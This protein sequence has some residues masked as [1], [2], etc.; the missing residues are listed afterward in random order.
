MPEQTVVPLAQL[1]TLG[2]GGPARRLVSGDSPV[3]M[4]RTV[5]ACDSV[6]ERLLVLAGGSNVVIPDRGFDGTVLLVRTR[7]VSLLR[8][9][10][11]AV[12]V[13]AQAGE[14]WDAL[15]ARCVA[16]GLAGL[17]CLAGIPGSVGATPIQNVGAYGQ[18]VSQTIAAVQAYDRRHHQVIELSPMDC[19]FSY[20][21]S[22]LKDLDR[23]VV[24]A[25]T[26][27]LTPGPL[28]EPV[29]YA[30]LAG[31][32]DL[33]VGERAALYDV[34]SAVL[35]LRRRKGMVL[36]P[37][38]P[39]TRSAGSFF[40][41]PV[42]STA[43]AARLPAEAPRWPQPGGGV[44]VSA[45]WLIERSGFGRGFGDGAIRVSTKHTLALTNRGGGTTDE[46][47]ALARRIRDGVRHRFGVELVPEPV[48][49]DE[50][51]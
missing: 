32:L 8:D 14:S 46:L 47:L 26:Y 15:V 18:E 7:G 9:G 36:D 35:E 51:W 10:S 41:N 3:E 28:S 44:K 11:G 4:V 31:A 49:I 24:L 43:D 22:M 12:S 29:R 19:R 27:R 6:G 37:S 5:A 48:L 38:D 50:Q 23:Y 21:H 30:E 33:H 42:L 34:R 25:V 20:R 17:E 1:T 45:A 2:L 40:T 16:E 13:V 39:D